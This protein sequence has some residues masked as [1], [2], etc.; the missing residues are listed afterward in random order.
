MI[1]ATIILWLFNLENQ[2]IIL[3]LEVSKTTIPLKYR[4]KV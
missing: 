3:L 4:N 1:F 2:V